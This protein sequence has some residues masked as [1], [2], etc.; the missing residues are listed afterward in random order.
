MYLNIKNLNKSFGETKVL[1]NISFSANKGEFITLL[2][3][4]GCG[5][6]TLLRCIAGLE[7]IDSGEIVIDSQAMHN[8]KPQKRQMGMVFQNYALFPNMH[9]LDNIMFG[10]KVAKTPIAERLKRAKSVIDMVELNGREHHYP[11]ELSGGQKQRVALARSLVMN[12]RVLF[13]DEPF[14][15]LDAKIRKSLR[16]QIRDIQQSLQLTTIF[17]THDQQEALMVSDQIL[18]LNAGIIEQRGQ[19][20]AIYT[21]P[22][23]QFAAGFI[24]NFNILNSQ[25][26]QQLLGINDTIAIRPEAICFANELPA[27]WQSV[28]QFSATIKHITLHG[29]VI[30]YEVVSNGITLNIEALNRD[31]SISVKSGDQASFAVAKHNCHRL[32]S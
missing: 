24:G 2:G 15:A 18:L 14:S 28:R 8:I 22:V 25:Q 11:H 32:T 16:Q 12:P 21:Q 1:N 10:M 3:P 13:L 5:K 19:A 4:S 31:Q 23:S 29:N 27:H 20:E 26:S 17:V 7:S 30:N 9:A 6:S